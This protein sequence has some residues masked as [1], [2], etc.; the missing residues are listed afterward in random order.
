MLVI[1]TIMI[2]SCNKPTPVV[3]SGEVERLRDF[4]SSFV[5]PRN[6]DI[7]LPD[8]YSPSSRY[9][10]IYMHDGQMLF[11]S[12]KTWNGQEWK[13]D[14]V[15]S[16]LIRSG[17]IKPCIVVGIWNNGEYRHT[18]YFPEK[19][20]GGL[21][22]EARGEIVRNFLKD[23]PLADEYLKFLVGE[24]KPYIDSHYSVLTDP[25]NTVIMG[26]SM[27]GL[28][29][30][31]ALCEY[32]EIFGRAGCLSTHWPMIS[33]DSTTS[34]TEVPVV[35]GMRRYL[36]ENLPDP[37]RHRVYFDY[38]TATLDSFY[39]PHQILVDEIMATAGYGK[40]NWITMKF[41]GADHS[42][43]SWSARLEMPLI[44]LLGT[45]AGGQIQ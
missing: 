32:P 28:I 5:D 11:D 41:E 31:Y 38:G 17:K 19:A 3:S 16:E 34:A 7:W 14:E 29:S 40:E 15:V 12:T 44:F 8:G 4:E 13:V 22:E 23:R 21:D 9:A 24:L 27:G 42:E 43:Q 35:A 26:S 2:A 6:V 39:E 33:P 20:L 10:V 36:S 18:E 45:D 25:E 1:L 37:E 30:L